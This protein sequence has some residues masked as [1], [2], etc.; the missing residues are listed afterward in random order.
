[1]FALGQD[2]PA[3]ASA[4]MSGR[5]YVSLPPTGASGPHGREV[6]RGVDLARERAGGPGVELVVLDSAGADREA[7]AGANAR[8]A[9]GDAGAVAYLGDFHSSQ[10]QRSAPVLADAGLLAVAPVATFAG[11]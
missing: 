4:P 5:V 10:V 1:M 3:V 8:T 7:Q 11:L 9:A 6:L 2:G